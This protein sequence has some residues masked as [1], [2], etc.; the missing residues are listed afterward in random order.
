MCDRALMC[1]IERMHDMTSDSAATLLQEALAIA[2][3]TEL[4]RRDTAESYWRR[5]NTLLKTNR[6]RLITALLAAGMKPTVPDGG[7]FLIA[8]FSSV[9]SKYEID[10]SS[11]QCQDAKF[12]KWLIKNKVNTHCYFYVIDCCC[13]T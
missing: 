7:Y 9:L 6:D 4:Q 13:L 8:D 1:P 12:V 11:E 10:D 5:L 3:E 2:F